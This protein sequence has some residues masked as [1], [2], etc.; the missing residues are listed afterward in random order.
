MAGERK[1]GQYGE[2]F[3]AVGFCRGVSSLC[4]ACCR[5]RHGFGQGRLVHDGSPNDEPWRSGDE[6]AHPVELSD[7]YIA[8][9][10]VTQAEWDAVTWNRASD[11]WRLPTEAEWEYACR[12]GSA[13][14]FSGRASIGPDEANFYGHYPYN[15]E[16]NYFTQEKLEVK[17]G[18]YRQRTTPAGSFAPN[19]L[20]L[21]D[22]HG[23]VGEW[24]WDTYGEYGSG[25]T[26][27]PAGPEE[28]S[29]R[30]RKVNRG[31]GWND[32]AKHLRCAY[33]ASLPPARSSASVGMRLA[34]NAVPMAGLLTSK[35]EVS[36]PG[37][38]EKKEPKVL[39]AFFSWGGT[40]RGIAGEVRKQTGGEL[41]RIETERPYPKEYR[42]TT[43]VAKREQ[44]EGAR[45]KL[46]ST[47]PDI[48]PYDVIFLGYPNW[49]GDMPMAVYT[50]LESYGSGA[51]AGKR[52]IPFCTAAGSGLSGTVGT[53]GKLCPGATVNN[54][55]TMLGAE[56][57]EFSDGARAKVRE[58]LVGT[59][60]V[61]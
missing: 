5:E 60:L 47:P 18:Q 59:G 36:E 54:A 12:A 8:A 26:K 49:W 23:N 44:N 30:M 39:V 38:G 40:T 2:I 46:K 25:G 17:P 34:R 3:G 22:M 56:A 51:F 55:F 6:T 15:I 45:P 31:G 27:D 53:I 13:E 57:Q 19:A 7:F 42:E 9:R 52:I 33:R 61:K 4:G 29:S 28:S 43:E 11:G 48:G 10:E 24:C 35:V 14:P 58:W 37:K 50:F 20:G 16:Q 32:F 1:E 41:F 21:Y